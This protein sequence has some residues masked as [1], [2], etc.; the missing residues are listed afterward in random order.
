MHRSRLAAIVIDNEVDDIEHANTFWEGALG[1]SCKRSDEQWA[2]RYS[3]L[4]TK[5]GHPHILIQKV[6]HPSRL[7]F[8]IETDNIEAE[9]IRLN[10]LGATVVKRFPRWVVMEAPTGHRFCVVHPQREDFSTALDVN[11]WE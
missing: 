9:V 7:H 1:L 2:E 5:Q 4:D 6:D 8:D 10:A 3:S 11:Q